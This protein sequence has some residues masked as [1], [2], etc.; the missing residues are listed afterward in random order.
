MKKTS[1]PMEKAMRLFLLAAAL[2]AL[3]AVSA[4]SDT[5]AQPPSLEGP[6]QEVRLG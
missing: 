5:A 4:C 6:W 2:G 3:L 1:Q